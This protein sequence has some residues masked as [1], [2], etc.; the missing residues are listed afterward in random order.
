MIIRSF[1]RRTTTRIYIALLTII[2]AAV[3]VL[4][5]LN[6][7]LGNQANKIYINSMRLIVSTEQDLYDVLRENENIINIRRGFLLE[8]PEDSI[9]FVDEDPNFDKPLSWSSFSYLSLTS[10]TTYLGDNDLVENEIELG[11]SSLDYYNSTIFLDDYLGKTITADYQGEELKLVI[12]KVYDAG[13]F[14]EIKI[15]KSIYD[16]LEKKDNRYFYSSQIKHEKFEESI[17]NDLLKYKKEEEDK[18]VVPHIFS[19]SSDGANYDILEKMNSQIKLLKNVTY[20]L[21]AIFL[22]M[23][24]I[25]SKNIFE[26]LETT[27]KLEYMLG[28]NKKNIQINLIKRIFSMYIITIILSNILSTTIVFTLNNKYNLGMPVLNFNFL[29]IILLV[30]LICNLLLIGTINNK[31]NITKHK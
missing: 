24:I 18:I 7:F 26:D 9:Q 27:L 30:I 11:F 31:L 8:S 6:A 2:I 28:F 19:Q 15:S 10:V 29:I 20:I 5:S 1:F 21:S 23:F 14:P 4:N 25:I 3:C 16:K 22:I 17:K 13:P 12:K